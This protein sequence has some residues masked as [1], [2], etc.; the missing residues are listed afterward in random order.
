MLMADILNSNDYKR[1]FE[2]GK[3][4]AMAGKDKNYIRLR[5]E[6][7]YEIHFISL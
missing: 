2:D 1:G 3:T 5:L 6:V 4:S 7:K